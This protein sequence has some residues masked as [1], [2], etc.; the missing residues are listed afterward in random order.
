MYGLASWLAGLDMYSLVNSIQYPDT[1]H[2]T[3]F[4]C[5]VV[6]IHKLSSWICWCWLLVLCRSFS[7][8]E[9][10]F[11]ICEKSIIVNRLVCLLLKC[12]S[13]PFCSDTQTLTDAQKEMRYSHRTK[14]KYASEENEATN[15]DI[16]FLYIIC[17]HQMMLCLCCQGDSTTA[18]SEREQGTKNNNNN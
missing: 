7:C 11:F 6:Y 1:I 3:S 2:N 15:T 10:Q 9:F 4:I 17:R 13:G 18:K 14:H 8:N 16:S 12:I 5:R